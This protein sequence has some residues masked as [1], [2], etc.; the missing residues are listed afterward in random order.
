M[1]E[2]RKN[3]I[4]DDK[5]RWDLLPLDLIEKVVEVYHFG[6]KKYAPNSWQNLPDG[7]NRY[8]AAL[9]R[10]LAAHQKGELKDPESGLLHL[11]HVCW[12]ALAML[13]FALNEDKQFNDLMRYKNGTL[14]TT[15][16]D[17]P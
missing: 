13:Y 15:Q 11:Q 16:T 3:D 5:L 17:N 4:Q 10:H 6:A 1:E 2:S 12:N 9:L 14:H 7:E 8:R